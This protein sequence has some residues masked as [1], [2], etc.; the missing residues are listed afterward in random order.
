MARYVVE[1]SARWAGDAPDAWSRT[2][3]FVAVSVSRED[4]SPVTGLAQSDFVVRCLE[5]P[6]GTIALSIFGFQEHLSGG[7]LVSGGYYWFGVTSFGASQSTEERP[8][9]L[10]DEVF[11]LVTVRGAGNNGQTLCLAQYHFFA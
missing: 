3:I 8:E 10:Q 2:P 1:A 11:V 7:P 4:G 9:F 6:Y 5:R